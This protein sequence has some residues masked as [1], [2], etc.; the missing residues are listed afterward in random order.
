VKHLTNSRCLGI[1]PL[2]FATVLTFYVPTHCQ[3]RETRTYDDDD[4]NQ[5]SFNLRMLHIMGKQKRRRR[6]PELAL[7]QLQEDFTYLQ[8]I[9]K[10]L[11]LA[12]LS[13]AGLDLKFVT[14]SATEINQRAERLKENLALPIPAEPAEPYK[15]YTVVNA[16]QLKA[17][18][19]ELA[20]LVV[21]FADNP[22]FKE[23]SVLETVNANV[24]HRDL[25]RIILLSEEIRNLSKS[26]GN[27]QSSAQ[28]ATPSTMQ[29]DKKNWGP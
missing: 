14:K 5:R 6:S 28:S 3:R 22:L 1:T 11:G 13:D 25:A 29:S 18:I 21:D 9:N 23:A 8:R 10:R 2:I 20:R 27:R 19:V 24:A 4:I 17:P 7:A 15:Q 26:L 12:A 16:T